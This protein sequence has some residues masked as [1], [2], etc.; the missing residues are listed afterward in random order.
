MI[1]AQGFSHE[2]GATEL[3]NDIAKLGE[4]RDHLEVRR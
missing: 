1:F 2:H 4:K 3:I